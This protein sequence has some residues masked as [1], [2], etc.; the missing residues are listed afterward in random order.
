M[1]R[2]ITNGHYKT[3]RDGRCSVFMTNEVDCDIIARKFELQ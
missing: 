3:N 2:N 1:P